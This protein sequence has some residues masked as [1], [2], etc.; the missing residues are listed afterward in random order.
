MTNALLLLV[1]LLATPSVALDDGSPIPWGARGHE[2]AARAATETLPNGIPDFFRGSADQL[3]YLN[4]DPD[5]WRER[6]LREMDQAWTYDHY[7]DLENVPPGALDRGDRWVF[8]KALYEAGLEKP[9]RD[10]GFLPF[11]TIEMY[12]RLVTEWRLWRAE[13]DP[14]KRAWIEA[15]IVNDAGILGHYVLDATNPLHTTIH[16]NGWSSGAPNPN[17]YTTGQDFHRRFESEFV[18]AKIGYGD[19]RTRVTSEPRSVAGAGRE[20]VMDHI[21]RSHAQVETLYRLDKEVGFHASAPLDPRTRDFAAERLADGA[22]MLRD[23]WW[24]AWLE[25]GTEVPRG[26]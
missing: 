26:G 18:R 23:L 3:I 10:V 19:I 16:F 6:A 22:R 21:H 17:G 9:E 15:R 14:G 24:S 20:A 25:S 4:P 2:M 7:I 11:R 8:L 5:R 12:Q 13:T 1:I